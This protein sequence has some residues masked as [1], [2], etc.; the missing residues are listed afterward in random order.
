MKITKQSKKS[1]QATDKKR[2]FSTTLQQSEIVFAYLQ[3]SA[4]QRIRRPTHTSLPLIGVAS[5]FRRSPGCSS[6]RSAPPPRGIDRRPP[7]PSDWMEAARVP[8]TRRRR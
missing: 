3:C 8:T 2:M 4:D 5:F 7:G 1:V 6:H